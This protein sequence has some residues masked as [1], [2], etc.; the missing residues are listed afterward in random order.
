[1]EAGFRFTQYVL[2]VM[3]GTERRESP[4]VMYT[5]PWWRPNF[6]PPEAFLLR[7]SHL[8]HHFILL[9]TRGMK[10]W[11]PMGRGA[12]PGRIIPNCTSGLVL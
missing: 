8:W 2:H 3:K 7:S 4:S 1:M 6:K 9:V 5:P 11:L 12:N 10:I